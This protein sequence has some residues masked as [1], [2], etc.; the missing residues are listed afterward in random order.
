MENE[1]PTWISYSIDIFL[2]LIFF[3]ILFFVKPE[4]IESDIDQPE[5]NPLEKM[6][7]TEQDTEDETNETEIDD[8][9]Y[10]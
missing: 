4:P 5:P 2:L 9:D 3:A 7:V 10:R 8:D 6:L 1:I